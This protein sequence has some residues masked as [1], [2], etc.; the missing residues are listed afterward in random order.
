MIWRSPRR[1]GA[2]AP[3][4]IQTFRVA[5]A[6]VCILLVLFVGATQLLHQHT[7]GDAQNPNCSL[8]AVAHLS[9]TVSPVAQTPA[10]AETLQVVCRPAKRVAPARAFPFN[11]YVRPPPALSANV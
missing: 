6:F 7:A 4:F 5:I 10:V 3:S 9:A 2:S 8:C 11:L 1:D